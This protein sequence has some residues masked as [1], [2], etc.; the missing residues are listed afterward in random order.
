MKPRPLLRTLLLAW[1]IGLSWFSPAWA[2]TEAPAQVKAGEK[3]APGPAADAPAADVATLLPIRVTPLGDLPEALTLESPRNVDDLRAIQQHVRDVV[4]KVQ[5]AVVGVMAGGGT[6]SGVIISEDGYVLTAGH[7]SAQPGRRVSLILPDGK[8]VRGRTLGRNWNVDGGL[9][10]IEDRDEDRKWPHV[11]VGELSSL[12]AGYWC[13]ALGHPGGFQMG[14]PPVVRLGRILE[15][16]ER[17]ITTDC[18]LV[19]GDSGG[20]LFDLSG[21]VIG[22][23]S[24]ISA[25]TSINVHVPI[26][27]YL[28]TWNRLAASEDF[29]GAPFLGVTAM[30]HEKGAKILTVEDGA[31]ASRVDLRKDDVITKFDDKTFDGFQG[32]VR[33]IREHEPGDEVVLELLREDR[34]MSL[35]IKLGRKPG[36]AVP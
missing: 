23:H 34:P 18:T 6:G 36:A 15:M 32:L 24:R 20:P 35:K 21:R 1:A 25:P 12:K 19:G 26:D 17:S 14:R 9:I 16:N 11:D 33:L 4:E 31:V 3:S 7:V 2:Q 10:K 22:I 30:N 8:R 5:G 13:I 29:G 28:D 27:S